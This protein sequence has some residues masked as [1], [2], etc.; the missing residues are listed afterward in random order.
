VL[1]KR[2]VD[3]LLNMNVRERPLIMRNAGLLPASVACFAWSGPKRRTLVAVGSLPRRRG[4]LEVASRDR[5][6]GREGFRLRM[7]A[8]A[9]LETCFAQS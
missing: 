4:P 2:I 5:M 9:E 8:E 6:V 3:Q 7:I 1:S